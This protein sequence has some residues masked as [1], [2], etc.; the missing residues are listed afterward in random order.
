MLLASGYRVTQPAPKVV[1]ATNRYGN[2]SLYP[3]LKPKNIF[4]VLPS[5]IIILIIA[6]CYEKF[7]KQRVIADALTGFKPVV[8]GLIAAACLSVVKKA[9]FPAGVMLSAI[10]TY[11]FI[12]SVV[13]AVILFV[14]KKYKMKAVLIIAASAV[15]GILAGVVH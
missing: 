9:F 14:M 5:F 8:I 11:E 3:T 6:K 12:S 13:I 10:P 2:L 1:V 4:S 7:R 15:L